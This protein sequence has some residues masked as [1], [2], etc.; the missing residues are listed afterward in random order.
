MQA[1]KQAFKTVMS[2]AQTRF[3]GDARNT[4][5]PER[6]HRARFGVYFFSDREDES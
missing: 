1:W 4:T 3:D 5:P 2:E 6:R